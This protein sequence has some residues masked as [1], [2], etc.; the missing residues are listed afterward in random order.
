MTIIIIIIIEIQQTQQTFKRKKNSFRKDGDDDDCLFLFYFFFFP[1][2]YWWWWWTHHS[3]ASSFNSIQF[4]SNHSR[5]LKTLPPPIYIYGM[6]VYILTMA[7]ACCFLTHE[8]SQSFKS[9]CVF[10]KGEKRLSSFIYV[11][12]EWILLFLALVFL[13][14][15]FYTL[16]GPS[17]VNIQLIKW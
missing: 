16:Y 13:S 8:S 6:Y 14:F 1:F 15:S 11:V 12:N 7:A 10:E 2:A 5:R 17:G 4:N 9:V 3:L